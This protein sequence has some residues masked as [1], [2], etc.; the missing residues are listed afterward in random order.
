MLEGEGGESQGWVR[1]KPQGGVYVGPLFSLNLTEPSH[2]STFP[3]HLAARL[4][5]EPLPLPPKD[6]CD[7]PSPAHLFLYEESVLRMQ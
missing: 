4:G 5:P 2:C 3:G 6:T 1:A 7:V